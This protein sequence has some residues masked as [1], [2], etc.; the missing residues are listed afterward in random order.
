VL[1][2]FLSDLF[3]WFIRLLRLLQGNPVEHNPIERILATVTTAGFLL[4]V[5]IACRAIE[6]IARR[7]RS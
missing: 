7:R 3:N 4:S 6:Q 2:S 5:Y 1:L